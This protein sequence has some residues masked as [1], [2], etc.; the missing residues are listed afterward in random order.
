[1]IPGDIGAEIARFLHAGTAA[2]EWPMAAAG[3]SVT[4]TWRPVPPDIESDPRGYATSLP[5]S[6]AR[7]TRRPVASVA[8]ALAGGLATL[9][10][11][12][13][14]RVTGHG[15]LTITVTADYLAALAPR[16]VAAG[17]A[18][19]NSDALAGRRVS[20][21]PWPDLS[22]A[23][24]WEQA[25][26]ARRDAVSGLLAQAAGAQVDFPGAQ[27]DL[28]RSS[29][30]QA[31]SGD[32]PAAVAASAPVGDAVAF[33]GADAV[34][35]ALA[36]ASGPHASTITRQL[37]LPL[38]LTNPFVI[39]RYAHAD[40]ASTLRWAADLKLL[41]RTEPCR[42]TAAASSGDLTRPEL[43]LLGAMS[44]L[45]ERVAAAARRRRPA[46]LAVHLEDLAGAWL[47]YR[48]SCPALPFQGSAAPR[49]A[50][51]SRAAARLC[52]ADAARIT[53]SAALTLLGIG[54][55]D[56]L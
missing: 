54:A 15:Y 35:Y 20:A 14:A 3:L 5:L 37:G 4:G 46:E 23:A 7:L 16:I 56:R 51:T 18:V 11:V 10:W 47:D 13:T 31:G 19:A 25:W 28:A 21:P 40:A 36:R 38:D 26:H 12:S 30:A 17:R 49:R 22:A 27:Q 9:P 53:L 24:T 52:L 55:P 50:E 34:G 44:W 29:S 32:A 8:Q 43:A 1:M 42:A 6:L 41:A 33:H 2:G 48:E 39:A 45:P